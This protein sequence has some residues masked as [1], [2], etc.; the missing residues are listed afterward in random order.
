MIISPCG[1]DCQNCM[2]TIGDKF[3]GFS[4]AGCN[5]VE[6]KIF[7]TKFMNL[8]ACPI[9]TCC[10]TVKMYDNCGQCTELPCAIFYSTKDPSLSDEEFQSGILERVAMLKR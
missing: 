9:Y 6:G 10:K 7:W 5:A 4:C 1:I 8:D 2:N 3:P